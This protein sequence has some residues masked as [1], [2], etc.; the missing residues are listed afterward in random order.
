MADDDALERLRAA[1][2][3]STEGEDDQTGGICWTCLVDWPCDTAVL[4]DRLEALA[5]AP[6]SD[7]G[8]DGPAG[9]RDGAVA[10]LASTAMPPADEVARL[11]AAIADIDAH[12]TPIGRDADG[13]V[14]GG[15]LISV[16]C[17][18]RALALAYTAPPCPTCEAS[19]HDCAAPPV[20]P[21]GDGDG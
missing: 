14:A 15:Y 1:H 12:A 5:S 8:T 20:T 19:S 13:F 9:P 17:L 7:A 21:Q 3:C 16:G 10:A 4:L 6:A 18:H 11:K 2:P